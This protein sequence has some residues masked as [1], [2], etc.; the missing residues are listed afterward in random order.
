MKNFLAVIPARKGSTELK[1]KN[2]LKFNQ[3]PLI[4]WTIKEALKSKY[5]DDIIVSSDSGKI[6][7]Y[8][9]KFKKI[10]ASFRPKKYAKK[11]YEHA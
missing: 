6:L 10:T 2:F 11:K 5:I 4:Y 7:N 8:C 9:K 3:K 1:N